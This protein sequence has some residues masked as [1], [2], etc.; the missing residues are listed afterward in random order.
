[1]RNHFATRFLGLVLAALAG[2]CPSRNAEAEQHDRW[3]DDMIRFAQQDREYPTRSGAVVFVGS[4]SIRLWNLE[5]SFSDLDPAPLNRGFGGSELED[6]VRHVDLLINKHEP[7]L[8]VVYAG[9]NDVAG[10]KDAARVVGDFKQLVQLI[11]SNLPRTNIAYIAIKP[12]IARWNL[13]DTMHEANRQIAELCA[14]NERLTFV[15]VWEPMLGEDGKP[16]KELFQD[17]GLHLNEDGYELWASLLAPVID[18]SDEEHQ[19]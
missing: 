13:S 12:S 16:R 6:S 9:D 5:K 3:A 7:R 2:V 4:S 19:P 15:D 10:G 1:M 11:Q 8:V 18:P 14:E 17:D